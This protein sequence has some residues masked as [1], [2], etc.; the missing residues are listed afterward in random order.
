MP[1]EEAAEELESNADD[2]AE[3]EHGG[4]A[5]AEGFLCGDGMPQE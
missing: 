5:S 1:R 2:A 4:P 3:D